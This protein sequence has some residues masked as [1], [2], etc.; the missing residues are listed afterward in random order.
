M[1]SFAVAIMVATFGLCGFLIQPVPCAEPP[2]NSNEPKSEDGPNTQPPPGKA[3]KCYDCKESNVTACGKLQNG[4]EVETCSQDVKACYEASIL[5]AKNEVV[6]TVRGCS[7][8]SKCAYV[9]PSSKIHKVKCCGICYKECCNYILST[10]SNGHPLLTGSAVQCAL[11]S[12][13]VG[14]RMFFQTM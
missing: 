8:T 11:V 13:L 14:A 12:S 7:S 6:G 1:K 4:W 5:N 3:F 2:A 10:P 9:L